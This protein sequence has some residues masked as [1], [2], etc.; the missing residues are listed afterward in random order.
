MLVLKCRTRLPERQPDEGV[1]SGCDY[2]GQSAF[3]PVSNSIILQHAHMI[4]VGAHRPSIISH[5]I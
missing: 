1:T 4:H 2:T 3:N 5:E